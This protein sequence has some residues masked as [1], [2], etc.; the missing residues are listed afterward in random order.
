MEKYDDIPTLKSL[1]VF[2]VVFFGIWAF[3]SGGIAWLDP[4]RDFVASLSFELKG[5]VL[6]SFIIAVL[7]A[8]RIMV[9]ITKGFG[10]ETSE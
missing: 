2:A 5:L 7:A 9:L 4:L 1:A 8:A 6:A 3:A 10:K